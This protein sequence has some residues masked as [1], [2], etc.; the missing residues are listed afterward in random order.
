MNKNHDPR[1]GRFT[2]G[3]GGG[4]GPLSKPGRFDYLTRDSG[5]PPKPGETYG[6]RNLRLAQEAYDKGIA[7]P[8]VV[9]RDS[10]R[11]YQ[12]GMAKALRNSPDYFRN[13]GGKKFKP[14]KI[15]PSRM[16]FTGAG[17]VLSKL[18]PTDPVIRNLRAL[19]Y[20]NVTGKVPKVGRSGVVHRHRRSG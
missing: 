6:E 7:P 8:N 11:L 5:P 2:T 16:A 3:G 9:G 20:V 13:P 15:K 10:R 17:D 4:T 14:P 12:Q 19:S 1:N 18:S